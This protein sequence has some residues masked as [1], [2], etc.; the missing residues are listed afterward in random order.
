MVALGEALQFTAAAH[1]ADGNLI[2]EVSFT[3]ASSDERIAA[4]TVSGLVTA[5]GNGAATVIASAG[6]VSG[7]ASVT[8]AQ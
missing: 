2:P 1:G 5:A 8:V 4:V 3:W 6:G 7:T